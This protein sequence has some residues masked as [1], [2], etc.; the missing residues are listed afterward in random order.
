MPRPYPLNRKLPTPV[1]ARSWWNYNTFNYPVYSWSWFWR[2]AGLFGPMSLLLGITLVL[3]IGQDAGDWSLAWQTA[4]RTCSAWLLITLLGP[5]LG[6]WIRHRNFMPD[7]ERQ[8]MVAAALVALGVAWLS[9]EW[10]YGFISDVVRPQLIGKGFSN[11]ANLTLSGRGRAAGSVGFWFIALWCSVE[12]LYAYYAELRRWKSYAI[13]REI[14]RTKQA[15]D[16]A[17]LR[18]AVL[19]AQVEPHFLYNTMASIRSLVRTDPA[20]AE[21]TID[22]L[23]DHLRATVPRIRDD[24]TLY[25]TL[26]SQLDICRSYLEVMRVRMGERFSYRIDAPPE[27]SELSFPPLM[28]ISLVENA[29]KHGVEPKRGSC[30]VA[31]A[32]R[33]TTADSA[34]CIE[35]SI[36]D[37]GAGLREGPS[38]GVGLANIRAQL[39]TRY[40]ARAALSLVG[41][42]SGGVVA[43]IRVPIEQ[44]RT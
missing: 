40:G 7:R 3:R 17:D 43:T 6:A 28:L 25:A 16:V 32:A 12:P 26:A 22:A 11:V 13:E 36:A 24:Q 39:T 4:L 38:E 35:V 27:L 44:S 9:R 2:Y 31:I 14:E 19:Q 5:A 29:I 42:A 21:A 10:Y 41:G 33:K 37:D 20:R 15:R 30:S 23:V 18:L 34:D 1:L 8:L